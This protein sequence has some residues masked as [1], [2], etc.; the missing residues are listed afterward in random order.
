M[1]TITL[2]ATEMKDAQ[3]SFISL[4]ERGANRI[5]FKIIKQESNMK[6][7]DLAGLGT[8]FTRKA[9]T[10][11]PEVVGVITLKS[12]GFE[13]VKS[14]I[15]DSGFSVAESAEMEDGSVVF[16]QG[17]MEGTATVIRVNDN[18]VMAVKGY[19]P[20]DMDITMADGTSFSEVCKS[21]GFYPGAGTT[22]DILRSAVLSLAEKSEDTTVTKEEVIRMFDEARNYVAD[23]VANLPAKAFKLELVFPE[24]VAK[25]PKC[26]ECGQDMPMD[27]SADGSADEGTENPD[28]SKKAKKEEGETV[29]KACKAKHKAK[30]EVPAAKEGEGETPAAEGTP[31]AS[32]AAPVAKEEVPAV[33]TEEQVAGIVTTHVEKVTS[34]LTTKM[35]EMLSAISG[36]ITDSMAGVT[37]SLEA[38]TGRVSEAEAV[39]KAAKEAISGTVVT[40]GDTGDHT[41]AKKSE[42]GSR[43]GREIDTA[44]LP[45]VR[46]QANR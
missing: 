16:K 21:Q 33:L 36:K 15:E 27:E 30:P 8:L 29:C 12:E 25:A 17:D 3:V 43:T 7:L 9:D 10:P 2:K 32:A 35:E 26:P 31:E 39:A 20:Y 42:M 5:P 23:M 34:D 18:A 14:Q 45:R 46:K 40:G 19:T 38:L 37:S 13:S 11:A 22:I 28:G 24:E 1:P 6:G 44:F 41:P 4:V